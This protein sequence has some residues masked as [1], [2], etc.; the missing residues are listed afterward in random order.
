[1]KYSLERLMRCCALT[2][3][4]R[5]ACLLALVFLVPMTAHAGACVGKFPNPITDICWKCIFPI[6]IGGVP[7]ASFSQEDFTEASVG[8]PVCVCPAP[9]PLFFRI[10]VT[11]SFWEPVRMIDVTRDPYCF[12]GIGGV[13][14]APAGLPI[15]A[16]EGQRRVD[17]QDDS[18]STH[19]VFYQAHYYIFPVGSLIEMAAD[20]A[21]MEP[22]SFDLAYL[23]ELDPLWADDELAFILNPESVIFANPIAQAACAADCAAASAGFPLTPLFWC[24]GCQGGV[25]PL[26]G[27]IEGNTVATSGIASSALIAQRMLFKLHRQGLLWGTVGEGALCT[28]VPMPIITK[29][30]YKTQLLYPVPETLGA[31]ALNPFCCQPLGRSTALWGIGKEF[32]VKGEDFSYL[33]WRKRD[34]CAL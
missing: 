31:G 34:C 19:S 25:Y 15:P 33:I 6:T 20:F 13:D 10:G 29:G 30:Q 21:C 4:A 8:A 7:V 32:P 12:V 22:S 1:M 9:P 27:H 14:G 24:A 26:T 11:V 23:T 18:G 2:A 16:P 28:K 5:Q 3:L 17:T